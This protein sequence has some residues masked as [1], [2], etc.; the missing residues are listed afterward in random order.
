LKVG[1]AIEQ[2]WEKQL[3]NYLKATD[4]EV[5]LLLNFGPAPQFRRLVFENERK[6]LRVHP[7]KS[8][9]ENSPKE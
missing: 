6:Q 9:E 2:A 4:I 5:G 7:R 3:L 1:R 8:A